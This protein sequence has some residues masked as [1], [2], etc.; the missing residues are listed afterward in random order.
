M[1]TG[2]NLGHEFREFHE[3]PGSARILRARVFVKEARW[4]RALPGVREIRGKDPGQLLSF[5]LLINVCALVALMIPALADPQIAQ[6]RPKVQFRVSAELVMVD[7]RALDSK[8]HPVQ[9]LKASDF[10]ILEDGVPQKVDS[11]REILLQP[12][13]AAATVESRR[14]I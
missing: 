14:L 5:A 6:T 9:G 2:R 4:K 8:N 11:F 1:R 10:E 12:S 13:P 3:I 7:L